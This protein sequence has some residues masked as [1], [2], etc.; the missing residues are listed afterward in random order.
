MPAPAG[1]LVAIVR[2]FC[3]AHQ[4]LSELVVRFRRDALRFEELTGLVGDDDS[5]VLFRLKERSHSLFR[6]RG[7]VD[8]VRREVLFDLAVGSLFHEA[9]SFRENFYQREVYGPKVRALRAVG[10]GESDALFREFEK[11]LAS[12]DQRLCEGLS[13]L[14]A[15]LSRTRDQLLSMLRESREN[16]AL[17][18]HLIEARE[19]VE[20]VFG[21]ALSPLMTLLFGD[22]AS[23]Y[24]LAGR[25][26]LATG[27]YPEAERA[28]EAAATAGS[29]SDLG[30]LCAC[31]AGFQAF[32]AGSYATS[33]EQLRRWWDAGAGGAAP[34]P[35]PGEAA[36]GDRQLAGLAAAIAARISRHAESEGN[37]ELPGLARRLEQSIRDRLAEPGS[38][39]S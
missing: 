3:R 28:F 4:L 5:S 29:R 18:R 34:G 25:S 37:R 6:A 35:G 16:G 27:Y 24:E 21:L 38:I 10:D 23:G 33:L 12:A 39:S 8:A 19:S 17:A 20:P 2:D 7:A 14:E 13:E 32:R 36:V 15:L 26:Y 9:M 30:P 31:A 1:T 22:L 11:I